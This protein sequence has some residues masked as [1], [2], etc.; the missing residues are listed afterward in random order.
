MFTDFENY[1]PTRTE[2][3]TL[4]LLVVYG[5]TV[6]VLV[7]VDRWPFWAAVLAPPRR[8]VAWLGM[9]LVAW[10]TFCLARPAVGLAAVRQIDAWGRFA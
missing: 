9:A 3:A 4:W 6:A 8:I 1:V 7:G 2:L 5:I 10:G